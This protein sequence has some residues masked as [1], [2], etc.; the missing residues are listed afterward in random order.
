MRYRCLIVDHDDTAVDSTR[1]IHY[2]AHLEVMRLL[3]PNARPVGIDEWY[4]KNF[5]PGIMAYL[6]GELG[7]SEEELAEEFRI[8][9]EFTSTRIPDFFPG[10]LDLLEEFRS[11]GGR[12]SVVSHSERHIIER[13]Y[14]AGSQ[15]R[16]SGKL[17]MPDLI[18]GWDHDE[19]FRKPSAWPVEQTLD[20]FRCAPDEAL[21]VDDLKPAVLMGQAS[22][23]SVAAAGWSHS[24]PA[25][26]D[27]MRE[28][29]IAYFE[30]VEELRRF[31][32]DE[33]D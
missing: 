19:H 16:N 7:L 13:D 12:I 17:I 18:F 10:F 27:F 9:Q 8:W 23:V 32:L 6:T 24:I 25:I 21:I 22:G 5:H 30:S 28:S 20:A 31:I 4:T 3:R 29:C 2:P 33:K 14:R 26:R 1:E 15:Q 11:R